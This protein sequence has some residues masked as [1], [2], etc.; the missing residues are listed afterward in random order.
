[1]SPATSDSHRAHP[2]RHCPT[3]PVA[4]AI[5]ACLCG[6]MALMGC[7]TFRVPTPENFAKVKSSTERLGALTPQEDKL[8][9][10]HFVVPDRQPLKFWSD[11]VRNNFVE[12]R[13]YTPVSEGEFKTDAGLAGHRFLAE[14][15]INS[16]PYDYLMVLFATE[17]SRGFFW[18]RQ[19][20]YVAEFLCEKKNYEKNAPAVEKALK[21]FVARR[22]RAVVAAAS[23]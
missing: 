18:K 7:A 3:T 11:T 13:G 8:L 5:V 19:H 14:I 10:R 15:S 4:A 12:E 21:K 9:V 1:M 2:R 22:G 17:G 6:L 23:K 20:V 16:V